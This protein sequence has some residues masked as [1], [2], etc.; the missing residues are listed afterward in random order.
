MMG[1]SVQ[2]HFVHLTL[3]FGFSWLS[4]SPNC[5]NLATSLLPLGWRFVVDPL[6]KHA[7]LPNG[8]SG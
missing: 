6:S 8:A 5:T 2:R 7:G 4:S 1:L 3:S